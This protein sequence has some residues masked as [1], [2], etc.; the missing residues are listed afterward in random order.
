MPVVHVNVIAGRSPEKL[1][2][3]AK[4]VTEAVAESLDAPM[5]SVRVLV[6]E[7]APE[8]WFVAGEPKSPPAS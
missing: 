1:A 6:H 4:R 3:M 7:I 2:T 5:S 8:H